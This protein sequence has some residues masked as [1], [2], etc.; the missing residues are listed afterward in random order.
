MNRPLASFLIGAV[1]MSS[2]LAAQDRPVVFVHGLMGTELGW[3][4]LADYLRPRWQ[5]F[6]IPFTTDWTQTE[7]NQAAALHAALGSYTGVTAVSHSNGGIVTRQYARGF[8]AATRV[9]QHLAIGSLHRGAQLAA[10]VRN[11]NV[12]LYAGWLAN[13]VVEPFAFYDT[14]DPDFHSI[15]PPVLYDLFY[16]FYNVA[17][18]YTQGVAVLGFPVPAIANPPVLAQMGP[19]SSLIT[20]LNSTAN[21]NA[22]A[23][24]F[25]QR[26]GIATAI[27][28]EDIVAR[29]WCGS[30]CREGRLALEYYALLM[31]TYYQDHPDLWLRSHAP[32][33]E[34]LFWAMYDFN[35]VW[36]SFIGSLI[37]YD[38]YQAVVQAQDGILPWSTQT[39]I[40]GTRQINIADKEIMHFYQRVDPRVWQSVEDVFSTNFGLVRRAPIPP[41]NAT[42]AGPSPITAKGTYTWE[43][44]PSGGVGGYT[45]QWSVHFYGTGMSLTL[46]TLKTQ[47]MTVYQSDGDFDLTVVVGS[48]GQTHTT[49]RYIEN[50]IPGGTPPPPPP[51]C[52]SVAMQSSSTPVG[53]VR[54]VP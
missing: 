41:V 7:E 14:E 45:Y 22:E 46:G 34:R 13:A 10:N 20:A 17:S 26:V 37:S 24:R 5:M 54:C 21:L 19:S 2:A 18:V 3:R 33:W 47:Q 35:V 36:H 9:N 23:V 11:G 29:L 44:M 43:A 30:A 1:L 49:T 40:N 53:M 39:Y 27:S 42:I 25:P 31:F 48:G 50:T 15:I 28:P 52:P 51:P 32:L 16:L 4:P 8:G 6:N 38:N 12:P